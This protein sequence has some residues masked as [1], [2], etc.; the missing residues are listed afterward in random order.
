ML[1]P[2]EK[3]KTGYVSRL[4]EL[5]K[6]YLVTQTY[7]RAG[8]TGIGNKIPLILSD[9][10]DLGLAKIHYKAV[11]NDKYSAIIH[12]ARPAH[13]EK[14]VYMTGPDS[15]YEMYWAVVKSKIQLEQQVNKKYKDKMRAYITENTTWRL[16]KDS[17][18]RPS[19]QLIFGELFIV[20]KHG[21]QVVRVKFEELEK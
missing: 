1:Q 7:N 17:G 3:F 6:L 13:K 19:V 21:K 12:L 20:I 9:Y 10:D 11:L 4:I 18:I 8:G 16:E 5:D 2:F 14:L 15:P